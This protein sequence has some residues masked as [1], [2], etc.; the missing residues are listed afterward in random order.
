MNKSEGYHMVMEIWMDE[1]DPL[2][3]M[4]T[5]IVFQYIDLSP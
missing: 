4:S 3:K 2:L 1:T 5:L